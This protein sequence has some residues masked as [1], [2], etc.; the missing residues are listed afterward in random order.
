M[1]HKFM[2]MD[3]FNNIKIFVNIGL[4]AAS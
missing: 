4:F 3:S 1:A 2:G